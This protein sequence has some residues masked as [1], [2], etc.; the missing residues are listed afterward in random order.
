MSPTRKAVALLLKCSQSVWR[1]LVLRQVAEE[2]GKANA[3]EPSAHDLWLAW[4]QVRRAIDYLEA[5]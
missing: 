4:L 1:D 2:E 3:A 5:A